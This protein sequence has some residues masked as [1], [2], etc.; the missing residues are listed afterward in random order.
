MVFIRDI[1]S[2][3][4]IS[5][6]KIEKKLSKDVLVLV[7]ESLKNKKIH[8][9][10]IRYILEKIVSG[11]S[12]EKAIKIEKEDLNICNEKIMKFIKENHGLSDK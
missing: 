6:E 11:E 8:E 5:F 4:K 7:L 1:S 10:D 3:R 9:K 12:P 2:K